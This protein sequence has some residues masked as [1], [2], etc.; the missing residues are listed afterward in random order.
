MPSAKI[1]KRWIA[2]F[3]SGNRLRNNGAEREK[4]AS[5]KKELASKRWKHVQHYADAKTDGIKEI[6]DAGEKSQNN[7]L[8]F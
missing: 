2:C 7:L 3:D 4:Y 1:P 8:I 5:V 6:L